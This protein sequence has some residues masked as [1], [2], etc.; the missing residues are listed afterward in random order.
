MNYDVGAAGA[1]LQALRR[2]HD[3][4]VETETQKQ[5]AIGMQTEL[6]ALSSRSISYRTDVASASSN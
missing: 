3:E 6:R 2:Q 1:V 5:F 4:M